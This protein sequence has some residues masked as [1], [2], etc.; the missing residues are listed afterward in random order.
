MAGSISYARLPA[1]KCASTYAGSGAPTDR[2]IIEQKFG[3][4]AH[5]GRKRCDSAVELM[6]RTNSSGIGP[7]INR[8]AAPP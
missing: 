3:E 6:T 7:A 8:R 2:H 4:M 5:V 1:L